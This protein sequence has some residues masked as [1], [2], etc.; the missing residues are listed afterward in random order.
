MVYRIIIKDNYINKTRT[1]NVNA[2]DSFEAHK[3]GLR[4]VNLAKEDIYKI[5][6]SDNEQV[7]NL[8]NGFT[9]VY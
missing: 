8:N 6:N 2:N 1:F 3:S 7:Y 4:T 5:F 9:S